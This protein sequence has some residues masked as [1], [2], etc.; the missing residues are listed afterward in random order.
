LEKWVDPA[1]ELAGKAKQLHVL[2]NNCYQDYGVRNAAQIA[3]LLTRER[4]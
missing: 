1:R 4:R 2:M 3:D